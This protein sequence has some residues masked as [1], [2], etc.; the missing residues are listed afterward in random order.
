MKKI[1]VFIVMLALLSNCA[2]NLRHYRQYQTTE[3]VV[4]SARVG[5]TIDPEERVQFDLFPEIEGFKEA[6]FFGITGG[7]YEVRIETES[8]KFAAA[9]RDSLAVM[10]LRDY[11]NRYEEIQNARSNFEKNWKIIDYDNMG[12]P[13]TQY[14]LNRIR[15]P[16]SGRMI[17]GATCCIGGGI[18][19]L[20]LA[21]LSGERELFSEEVGDLLFIG[22]WAASTATG[23]ILG[24]KIFRSRALNAIKESRKP[25]VVE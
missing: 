22:T 7:G 11:I 24:E 6:T 14:E 1:F 15:K 9:N 4:I 13:I 21:E 8:E 2:H 17:G 5:P 19:S 25:R 23:V 20:A 10:I 12:L 18:T 16:G 3:R